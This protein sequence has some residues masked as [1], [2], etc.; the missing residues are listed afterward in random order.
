MDNRTFID[1]VMA[2]VPVGTVLPNPGGG[3][4]TVLSI[5]G[6]H[7]GYRR[8]AS[9][10][11]ARFGDL[12]RAYAKYRGQTVSSTQL[13]LWEPGIFDSDHGGHSCHS[14]F[15][16]MVLNEIGVADAM[17]GRGKRG[18]PF[19]VYIHE[20]ANDELSARTSIGG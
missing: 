16:F 18:D 7:I 4:S 20:D 11:T 5:N 19:C 1:R 14:T 8:G 17:R 9:R 6:T 3:N 10:L 2:A 15:L 13:R 12:Y